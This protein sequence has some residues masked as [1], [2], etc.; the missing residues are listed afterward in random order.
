MFTPNKRY[1]ITFNGEI[2]NFLELRKELG[3]I[4]ETEPATEVILAAYERWG[5]ACQL[6]FNGM[7]AFAI[8]DSW[9][10]TLFLSR[11][12]FG[13]K[14]LYFYQ[15]ENFFAFASEMKAFLFLPS[16]NLEFNSSA[17]GANLRNFSLLEATSYTLLNN[18]FKL[19]AGHSALFKNGKL[20]ITRWWNTADHIETSSQSFTE[21]TEQ[22]SYLFEDACRIRMRSDVPIGCALSGGLD[23][24][25][26]VSTLARLQ[27]KN[28]RSKSSQPAT[29]T[30]RKMKELMLKS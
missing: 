11:D 29:K 4:F 19:Q 9:E 8:W 13:V 26:V 1:W 7:L 10:N 22:L 15:N 14:P 21:K 27:K 30:L 18:V 3:G 24:S 5:A 25:S 12:R 2:Y 17:V 20:Q 23:S 6:K 16:F 28:L